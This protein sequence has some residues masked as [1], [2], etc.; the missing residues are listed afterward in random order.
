M[1]FDLR[2]NTVANPDRPE[3]RPHDTA[4]G[5]LRE[6]KIFNNHFLISLL[7][8][9]SWDTKA[10]CNCPKVSMPAPEVKFKE[11]EV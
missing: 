4:D 8:G 3:I 11:Q 2:V 10:R 1:K 6:K 9:G 5:Y 7:P